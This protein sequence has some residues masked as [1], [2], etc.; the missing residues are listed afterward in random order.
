M[1]YFHRENTVPA[2]ENSFD[3]FS[4]IVLQIQKEHQ[5]SLSNKTPIE[6]HDMNYAI[7]RYQIEHPEVF[8]SLKV[9]KY[10]I[11]NE[12]RDV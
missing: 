7:N 4:Q 8:L 10:N 1:I 12:S 6:P 2:L 3:R 11:L 5:T 9:Y